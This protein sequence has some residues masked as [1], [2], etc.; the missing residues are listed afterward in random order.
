[1]YMRWASM[2]CLALERQLAVR[3]FSR[4]WAK[5]G[6]R[7][8]AR[9]AMMAMTTSSSIRVKPLRLTGCFM[10]I[11]FVDDDCVVTADDES[12]PGVPTARDARSAAD[13]P[14]KRCAGSPAP[15]R[16]QAWNLR[17]L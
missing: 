6:N 17:L 3:A 16:R 12:R 14:G 5:T 13:A 8:A 7:I 4:A 9:I 15:G 2:S 1:M 10:R 11:P